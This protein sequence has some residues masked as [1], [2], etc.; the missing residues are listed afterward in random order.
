VLLG[1]SGRESIHDL[2]NEAVEFGDD[3]WVA[4]ALVAMGRSSDDDWAPQV[5]DKLD[6]DSILVRLE[7]VRAAGDLG[8]PAATPA[9][10]YLLE[11]EEDDIRL[12]AAWALSEI[13]GEGVRDGLEALQVETDDENDVDIIEDAL[14]NLTLTEEIEAFNLLDLSEEDLEDYQD[15]P[16]LGDG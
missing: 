6:D 7:A 4:S 14:E 12:A 10:L 13:G 9:L 15:P 2:I 8:L 11:S 16:V 5:L 1:F 3:N